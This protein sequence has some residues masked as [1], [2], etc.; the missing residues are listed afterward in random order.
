MIL[1]CQCQAPA[2]LGVSTRGLMFYYC[3]ACAVRH[4]KTGK[5]LGQPRAPRYRRLLCA[6]G[7]HSTEKV[8]QSDIFGVL[9][10]CVHCGTEDF[11]RDWIKMWGHK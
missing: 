3:V 6:V 4:A 9:L 2:E 7:W 1:C 8:G 11:E 10:R 5:R